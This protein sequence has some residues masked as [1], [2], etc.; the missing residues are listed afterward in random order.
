MDCVISIVDL[1]IILSLLVVTKH[2]EAILFCHPCFGAGYRSQLLKARRVGGV[3]GHHGS[4][5]VVGL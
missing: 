5:K 3:K 1:D 2:D 4:L